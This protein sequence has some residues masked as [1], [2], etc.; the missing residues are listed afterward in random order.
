[1]TTL[2]Y[3]LVNTDLFWVIFVQICLF[4][5]L[6]SWPFIPVINRLLFIEVIKKLQNANFVWMIYKKMNKVIF[7]AT[8]MW[9]ACLFF[10]LMVIKRLQ[11]RDYSL[12]W[13][14]HAEI[15]HY[16]LCGNCR[17]LCICL[18]EK[19]AFQGFFFPKHAHKSMKQSRRTGIRFIL[20]GYINTTLICNIFDNIFLQVMIE[21]YTV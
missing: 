2:G 18:L 14:I 6:L 16:W 19:D 12:Y 17:R 20:N 9:L 13:T 1:M 5:S 21:N 7:D 11:I 4:C 10:R 15:Q 8:T 3:L